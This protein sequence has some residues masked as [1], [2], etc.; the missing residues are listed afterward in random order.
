MVHVLFFPMLNVLCF[1]ISTSRSMCAVLSMTVFCSSFISCFP[2]MLL[3]Y[4]LSDFEMVPVGHIIII[5]I[6][7]MFT[8]HLQ[9]VSEHHLRAYMD[10]IADICDK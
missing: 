2:S 6:S 3:R 4:F 7:F 8:F 10:G 5:C 1:Y 9:K